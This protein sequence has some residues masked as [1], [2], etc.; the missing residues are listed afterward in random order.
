MK[1]LRERRE[2]MFPHIKDW[3]DPQ[4]ELRYS[5]DIRG[6]T[7]MEWY[8]MSPSAYKLMHFGQPGL[9]A[10]VNICFAIYFFMIDWGILS[11]ALSVVVIYSLK[12]FHQ[13]FKN[14]NNITNFT[15][16]DL[17]LRDYLVTEVESVKETFKKGYEKE[18]V[19]SKDAERD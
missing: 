6:M 10:F 5:K 7:W 1:M 19:Q 8:W 12:Q 9:A 15:H 2:K 17:Y 11:L 18:V 4:D 14:R 3:T 16:Y 13:R